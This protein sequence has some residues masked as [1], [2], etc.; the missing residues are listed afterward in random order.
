MS[1]I[2]V[3]KIQKETSS[4]NIDVPSTGQFID[5]ASAAQGDVLYY[6]G[7][8]YV[9]LGA[10]TAGQVL[11]SGGAGAN[12]S[13]TTTG[14][15]QEVDQWYLTADYTGSVFPITTMARLN[16]GPY[17][18]PVGTG[19][20]YSSGTFSFPSTGKWLITFYMLCT[21]TTTADSGCNAL[22]KMSINS[23]GSY[24]QYAAA[25]ADT[26]AIGANAACN[27]T[28]IYLMD[29]PNISTHLVQIGSSLE[30]STNTVQG[31][32]D[33]TSTNVVFMKVGET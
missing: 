1:L 28:A 6:N 13:W 4:T 21:A 29:V 16:F 26:P 14:G 18:A 23:G 9:R 8:S 11:T 2:T 3:S 32:G 22:I 7:T 17:G 33:D 27:M 10:G 25:S 19:M 20:G 12:P 30:T 31:A 15:L 5:L 24:T